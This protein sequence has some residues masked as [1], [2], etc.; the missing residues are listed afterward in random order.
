MPNITWLDGKD[1]T[2]KF[3]LEIM[4]QDGGKGYLK[5]ESY[6]ET[7]KSYDFF[8]DSSKVVGL[9]IFDPEGKPVATRTRM[10]A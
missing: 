1:S 10:A 7:C 8:W 3:V 2:G 5:N 9:T 4:F 6:E